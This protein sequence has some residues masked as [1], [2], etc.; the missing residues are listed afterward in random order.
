VEV[1]GQTRRLTGNVEEQYREWRRMLH[2]IYSA[3][4]GFDSQTD[5]VQDVQQI[6]Y[7]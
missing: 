6:S 4:T 3:E 7:D 1:E 5:P 2:E